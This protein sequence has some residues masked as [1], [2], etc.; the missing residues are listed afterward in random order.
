MSQLGYRHR[1]DPNLRLSFHKK[2]ILIITYKRKHSHDL[3]VN[4]RFSCFLELYCKYLG[5]QPLLQVY[6]IYIDSLNH[7]PDQRSILN[8]HVNV[9]LS[10]ILK[11]TNFFNFTR[12]GF[13][14]L[15]LLHFN[16][17]GIITFLIG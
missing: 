4:F 15:K 2:E 1:F 8:S 10:V 16:N 11:F 14:L 3:T 6:Y 7:L 5:H 9:I 13:S 17:F 12:K